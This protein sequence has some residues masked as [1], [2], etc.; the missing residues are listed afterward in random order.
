MREDIISVLK[1][2]QWE[3]CKGE[4]N[5]MWALSGSRMCTYDDKDNKWEEIKDFITKFINDFES[6]GFNE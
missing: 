5:T 3:K 6:E 1:S 2:M 4:L